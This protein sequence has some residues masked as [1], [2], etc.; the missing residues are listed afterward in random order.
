MDHSRAQNRAHPRTV[1]DRTVFWLGLASLLTA[2]LSYAFAWNGG[3]WAAP[4]WLSLAVAAGW[5]GWVRWM[6]R[7]ARAGLAVAAIAVLVGGYGF[8]S[9]GGIQPA[10]RTDSSSYLPGDVVGV[11]LRAGIRSTGYNL[12]F[13]FATLERFDPAGWGPVDVGL[14]RGL[15]TAQQLI[16]P[17]LQGA[18]GSVH[19]PRDLPPGAYRLAYEVEVGGERRR[20]ATDRFTVAISSPR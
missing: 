17:T 6:S 11:Q 20:V 16:L 7:W 8:A 1:P 10:L 2:L 3:L 14:G 15:C 12:C 18:E 4:V 13:S 5:A 19:L 9:T